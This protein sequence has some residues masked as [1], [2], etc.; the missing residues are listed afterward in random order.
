MEGTLLMKQPVRVVFRSAA[1]TP[2]AA[3]EGLRVALYQG[4]GPVASHEAVRENLERLAQVGVA[5][6]EG[7][8][9][10]RL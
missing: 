6:A 5:L 2:P 4:Q 8:S 10:I 7:R 9:L 3:G 1:R